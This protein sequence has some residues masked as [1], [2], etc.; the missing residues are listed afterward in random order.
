LNS[1]ER[2]TAAINHKKTDRVPIDLGGTTVTGIHA[3]ALYKLKKFLKL[4]DTTVKVFHPFLMLGEVEEDIRKILNIDSVPL[5]NLYNSFGFKNDNYKL[6]E[7]PDGTPVFIG[8]DFVYSK[9]SDGNIYF[10]PG[11]NTDI[12]PSMKMAKNSMY[13]DDIVRQEP[14]TGLNLNAYNDYKEDYRTYNEEE[15]IHLEK[16]SKYLFENTQYAIIGDFGQGS[17]GDAG[18]ITGRLLARPKGMRKLEDW[19]M[20]HILYPQYVKERYEMQTEIA[21]K[22]LQLYK[23]AVHDRIQVIV[24]STTDFGSQNNEMIS[25]DMFR[26]FYKPYFAR[27]NNWVHNNT[28]WKT[29]F[30]SCGSIINLIDDFI[31]CGVDILNPVQCSASCMDPLTLSEKYGHKIVFWGGAI[32]T[33]STLQFKGIEAVTEEAKSRLEIFSKANGFIFSAVHNI[34]PLTPPENILALFKAALGS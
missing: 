26:E 20:A 33:Q 25:P 30:H 6:F 31:E 13:F 11:N 5:L 27:L 29:F 22:N 24:I 10:H 12:A 15:L 7:L 9:D 34:Q 19:F 21:L 23:E 16:N 3:A 2:I 8:G 14:L 18:R 4:S 17:F 28:N 1:R 32:D